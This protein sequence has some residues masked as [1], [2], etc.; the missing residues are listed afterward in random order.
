MPEIEFTIDKD[1]GITIKVE[2]VSGKS[3]TD[4][5]KDLEEA[6]GIVIDQEMTSEYYEEE[7][8]MEIKLGSE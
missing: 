2:G 1:G 5:T 7:D 3:C 4:I 6:F 8:R